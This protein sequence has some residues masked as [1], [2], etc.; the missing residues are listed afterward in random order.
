[1][2]LTTAAPGAAWSRTASFRP[3][4]PRVAPPGNQRWL[5]GGKLPS[6][7]QRRRGY[8]RRSGAGPSPSGV[9]SSPQSGVPV[10]CS[11]NMRGSGPGHV[12]PGLMPCPAVPRMRCSV[13][14]I[15]P[16]RSAQRSRH[17]GTDVPGKGRHL[18]ERWA[19]P[20]GFPAAIRVTDSWTEQQ[21]EGEDVPGTFAPAKQARKRNLVRP[22]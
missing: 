21:D 7:R 19:Q 2:T 4:A 3:L 6:G 1:M 22:A 10:S 12:H 9:S 11:K 5:P 16:R 18:A 20:S 8:R 13:C 17:P 15:S 14:R